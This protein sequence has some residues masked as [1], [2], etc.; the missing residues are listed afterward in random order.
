MLSFGSAL[1]IITNITYIFD[2]LPIPGLELTPLSFMLSGLFI[3][4]SMVRFRMCDLIPVAR[5]K[6]FNIIA[7]GVVI[8]D[9]LGRVVDSNPAMEK[10]IGMSSNQIIGQP[11]DR[12]FSPWKEV[13][14]V[15][16]GEKDG[17][18]EITLNVG[19]E[20]RC[21][22]LHLSVEGSTGNI[23]SCKI[24]VFR[25]ITKRRM[26]EIERE[27][28]ISELQKTLEQVKTLKGLIPIC[29]SCKKI[30]NDR[31][32]WEE[33]ENY[34]NAHSDATFTHSICPDC[35][36]KLYPEYVNGNDKV[37]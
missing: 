16:K 32:Y 1:P 28:L 31:G 29:A 20:S 35:M 30:R 5:E 13:Q 18:F 36:K 3:T 21:F 10:L 14:D 33:V 24:V 15:L 22:D 34:I 2:L 4:L 17:E 37:E 11:A 25:D 27:K 9:N 19:G 6:L 7:D 23:Y 26:M 12:V 8:V